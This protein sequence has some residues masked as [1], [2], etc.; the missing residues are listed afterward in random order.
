M[1]SETKTLMEEDGEEE[2]EGVEDESELRNADTTQA[3]SLPFCI[4]HSIAIKVV[5]IPLFFIFGAIF[6]KLTEGW[7]TV[8]SFYVC[9]QIITTI[10]Y[11]DVVPGSSGTRIFMIFYVLCIVCFVA[12]VLNDVGGIIAEKETSLVTSA[13]KDIASRQKISKVHAKSPFYGYHLDNLV[14][15]FIIFIVFALFGMFFYGGFE[16]CS[17]S[18]GTTRANNYE[19]CTEVANGTALN[20]AVYPYTNCQEDQG[21]TKTYLDA[22][23]MSI[24]TMT[25]VGFGDFYPASKFGRWLAILWMFLG[26]LSTGNL[27]TAIATSQNAYI[28]RAKKRNK[29]SQAKLVQLSAKHPER[30][31]ISRADFLEYMLYKQD[32]VSEQHIAQIDETYHSFVR[33]QSGRV[34]VDEVLEH[35][36]DDEDE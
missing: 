30:N 25:T 13:L 31:T 1:S 24:I 12:G 36:A 19:N 32:L 34:S 7:H 8:T 28:Q 22:F 9:M 6:L 10:G 20:G 26:V 15:A 35:L 14:G 21:Q 3:T 4:R 2:E 18:Y 11:G 16:R 17:C 27:V 29:D 23:Y 33:D 5:L